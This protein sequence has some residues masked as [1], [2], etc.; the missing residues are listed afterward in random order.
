MNKA[1]IELRAEAKKADVP[2]WAVAKYLNISEPTLTR[3]LR[4]ELSDEEKA[5]I[6][7]I[8]KELKEDSY[9]AENQNDSR[10]IPRNKV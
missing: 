2:L 1:N 6:A 7:M 10:S 8:I 4:V 5:Q 3:K 9:H